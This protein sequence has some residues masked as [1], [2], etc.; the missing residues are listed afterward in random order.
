[1]ERR[2]SVPEAHSRLP[3]LVG[4][5][6]EGKGEVVITTRNEPKAVEEFG[7]LAR[8][9]LRPMRPSPRNC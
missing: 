1:M 8:R 6:A 5:V 2:L 4:E 9:F 7:R 3:T